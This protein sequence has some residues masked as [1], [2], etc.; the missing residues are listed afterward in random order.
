M[1]IETKD[2]FV[3]KDGEQIATITGDIITSPK[4]LGPTVKGAIKKALDIDKLSF[5]VAGIGETQAAT[6]TSATTA[7]WQAMLSHSVGDVFT[8]VTGAVKA[9]DSTAPLSDAELLAELQRR[10]LAPVAPTIKQEEPQF[11]ARILNKQ[12]LVAKFSAITPP[13]ATL[14]DMGDKTPAFVEWVRSH[15]TAEEF[16]VIY[17][18]HRKQPSLAERDAGEKVRIAKLQRLPSETT[19]KK[20]DAE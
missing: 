2:G 15:A 16:A 19:D 18:A 3:Y 7:N 1:N 10:G 6:T 4:A 17:P 12:E 11:N 8:T 14:P 20:G 5:I 9:T 13:P